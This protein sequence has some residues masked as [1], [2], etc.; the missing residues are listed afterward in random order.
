[1]KNKIAIIIVFLTPIFCFSQSSTPSVINASGGSS[2]N[3]YYQF[4]WSIGEM[5]LVNEMGSSLN[6]L[7][8]LVVTNGFLQ[9]Y[10]LHETVNNPYG[11]L[12]PDEIK[13]FPT[14]ASSYVEI[15]LF[16]RQQGQLKIT[17]LDGIGQKV[18]SVEF[19]TYGVDLIHRIPIS[20]LSAG[21]YVLHLELNADAGF[22]SKRG[23]FKII[24]TE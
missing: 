24:K 11:I 14:P 18:Y 20:R 15:N 2:Q 4:E 8:R 19:H 3:G 16:T 9:P 7:N 21:A 6:S 10:L 1:M 5:S 12:G 17:F 22:V 13:V 23:S